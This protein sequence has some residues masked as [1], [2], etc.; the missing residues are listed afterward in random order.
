M[1]EIKFRWKSISTWKIVYWYYYCN[2]TEYNHFIRVQKDNHFIDITIIPETLWQYT[3]LLDKNLKEIYSGDVIKIHS[4]EE[5]DLCNMVV[6]FCRWQFTLQNLY[7]W[8]TIEDEHYQIFPQNNPHWL[9]NMDWTLED[10]EVIWNLFENP[11]LI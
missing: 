10:Y 6:S 7:E 4:L 1:K 9:V 2:Q 8:W 5:D 11:E 3:W